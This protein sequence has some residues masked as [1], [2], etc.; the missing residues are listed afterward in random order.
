[1]YHTIQV[2]LRL[3]EVSVS[4]SFPVIEHLI[5]VIQPDWTVDTHYIYNCDLPATSFV[6]M[7]ATKEECLE[8]IRIDKILRCFVLS[9]NYEPERRQRGLMEVEIIL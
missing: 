3:V 4:C 7:K 5:I 2:L 9:K 1:M 6:Q 8:T